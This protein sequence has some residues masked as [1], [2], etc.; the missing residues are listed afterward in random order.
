MQQLIR[1]T[2]VPIKY[3]VHSEPA[4]LEM[5]VSH[6]S[7]A[8]ATYSMQQRNA[9]I[10]LRAQNIQM[11]MDSYE[12]RK[13][14]GLKNIRDLAA[15]NAEK[16]RQQIQKLTQEYVQT[17]KQLARIDQGVDIGQIVQQKALEQ[18]TYYT[19]FLP[20]GEIE[21][22]WVPA[23]LDKQYQEGMLELD[24]QSK[25]N[26]FTY[27]PGSFSIEITQYPSVN[28]EYL[29]TPAYVPPSADPNY[30]PPAEE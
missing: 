13:S 27:V 10:N 19:A 2:T 20:N 25:K 4:R 1:I 11:R 26:I 21:I 29:G 3:E 23:Q 14:L 17:G 5:D 24:W 18:P 6:K 22:S 8:P 30:E 28:I 16:G 15:D 9:R 12:M 7:T